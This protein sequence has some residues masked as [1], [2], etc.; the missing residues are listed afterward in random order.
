[1]EIFIP[2]QTL[3]LFQVFAP[4]FT[5]PSFA[6]F[7]AYMW[8]LMVVEGRKCMTRLARCV[9]FHRRFPQRKIDQ[10]FGSFRE[11]HG[12]WKTTGRFRNQG[13]TWLGWSRA[14]SRRI[15]LWQRLSKCTT[16]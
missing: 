4:C 11:A 1:M 8:A 9:F 14:A 13:I 12:Y 7:Q 10:H 15:G 6:Y 3:S 5:A 2:A 16:S